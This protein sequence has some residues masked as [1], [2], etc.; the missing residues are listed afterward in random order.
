MHTR[1]SQPSACHSARQSWLLGSFK[2]DR[3]K[4]EQRK[5]GSIKVVSPLFHLPHKLLQLCSFVLDSFGEI[6]C[7]V[8]VASRQKLCFPEDKKG[9]S[10][11]IAFSLSTTTTNWVVS[12][13]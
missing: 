10:F 3:Q 7:D 9:F 13:V 12:S 11:V 4:E 5:Q 8:D 6:L 2:I 1:P